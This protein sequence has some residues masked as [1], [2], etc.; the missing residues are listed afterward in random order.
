M[1]YLTLPVI[2]TILILDLNLVFGQNIFI[3]GNIPNSGDGS[4]QT[5]FKTIEEGIT[6]V[7]TLPLVAQS[8]VK[9]TIAPA[10]YTLQS[11][12]QIQ[13]LPGVLT[14]EGTG[15]PIINCY[16]NGIS[17]SIKNTAATLKSLK[18]TNC[19]GFSVIDVSTGSNKNVDL[20][21]IQISDNFNIVSTPVNITLLDKTI[22]ITFRDCV[23][24]NNFLDRPTPDLT[25]FENSGMVL[26]FGT[27]LNTVPDVVFSNFTVRNITVQTYA[28]LGGVIRGVDAYIKI[29][30]SQIRNITITAA[31]TGTSAGTIGYTQNGKMEV[32]QS[33]FENNFAFQGSAFGSDDIEISNSY[34]ANHTGVSD[35]MFIINRNAKAVFQNVS[36]T[37]GRANARSLLNCFMEST[38]LGGAAIKLISDPAFTQKFYFIRSTFDGYSASDSMGLF[39]IDSTQKTD[40]VRIESHD[41]TYRNI[42]MKQ[43]LVVG[44][45][46]LHYDLFFN[47]TVVEDSWSAMSTIA[48]MYTATA[49]NYTL[50]MNNVTVRRNFGVG[51]LLS[52]A[53]ADITIQNCN[54]LN[55]FFY[56]GKIIAIHISYPFRDNVTIIDS[57]FSHNQGASAVS[58]IGNNIYATIQNNEISYNQN[59]Y[60]GG[61]IKLMTAN[62]QVLIQGNLF[63][64]NGAKFGG[65]I[66]AEP[67]GLWPFFDGVVTGKNNSFIIRK[68]TFVN[69]VGS[70]GGVIYSNLDDFDKDA[71]ISMN[72]YGNNTALI[73][74]ALFYFPRAQY[75]P[76]DLIN[77][78]KQ[79]LTQSPGLPNH[80]PYGEIVASD[81]YELHITKEIDSMQ[82]Y[83]GANLPDI[84]VSMIDEFGQN[85]ITP[86]DNVEQNALILMKGKFSSNKSATLLGGLC[87]VYDGKCTIRGQVLGNPGA[88]QFE[89]HPIATSF[90][91]LKS[92]NITLNLKINDCPQGQ[93]NSTSLQNSFKICQVPKC[94]SV[95][96]HG[97]CVGNNQ[98]ACETGYIGD[99]CEQRL[100]SKLSMDVIIS[101]KITASIA[102]ILLVILT[103]LVVGLG[104]KSIS[105]IQADKFLLLGIFCGCAL[106]FISLIII[107]DNEKSFSC[108]S[109]PIIQR[110]AFIAL[111]TMISNNTNKVLSAQTV[112]DTE[113][114]IGKREVNYKLRMVFILLMI[115]AYVGIVVAWLVVTSGTPTYKLLSTGSFYPSCKGSEVQFAILCG[116]LCILSIGAYWSLPYWDRTKVHKETRF[117]LI[118]L[119]NWVIAGP[120]LN[121]SL[122]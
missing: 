84:V 99:L 83:S 120:I 85:V 115:T 16:T 103:L 90:D 14:I 112:E 34:F 87:A 101:A 118:G 15:L 20:V 42:Q 11:S 106:D 64:S 23:F 2:L 93:V 82:L 19:A 21:G 43:G 29:T 76:Q 53:P 79:D 45:N 6:Y 116:E 51:L 25:K 61:A 110:I 30:N 70:F 71:Q 60:N 7:R 66:T 62:S 96:V 24:E 35:G 48:N 100:M 36:I 44:Y 3:N 22:Q 102:L 117:S 74:G 77:V 57:K 27:N 52:N 107:D 67:Q 9:L 86:T 72:K 18:F 54:T 73:G 59:G 17:I 78:T 65:V 95:C 105:F 38:N 50:F 121:V 80:A 32:D 13:N 33:V 89:I 41:S 108:I 88:S 94:D 75:C 68:N 92:Q 109:T 4:F 98:C 10:T 46:P 56:S 31:A 114:V 47:N 119:Y 40:T 97:S 104:F 69:N 8:T 63:D 49:V 122:F 55:N 28:A 5:P 58:L 111:F 37:K 91:N 1:N 39:E 113:S 26:V 81:P 12:I